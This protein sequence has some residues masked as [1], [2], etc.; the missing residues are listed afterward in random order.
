MRFA[1]PLV[2]LVDTIPLVR[3]HVVMAEALERFVGYVYLV[4]NRVNGKIYV[5]CTKASLAQ[6]WRQHRSAAKKGSPFALHA[7]IRKYGEGNFKIECIEKVGGDHDD[8]MVAE[9]LHIAA[10]Q[11]LV[12]IGYNLTE[13]GDGVDFQTH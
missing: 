12:P 1:R 8:L 13:G 10:R 9:M 5:G 2:Y 6:R 3:R 11:C 7:A 4:T